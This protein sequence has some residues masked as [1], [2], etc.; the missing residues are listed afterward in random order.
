MKTL[1]SRINY[2]KADIEDKTSKIDTLVEKQHDFDVAYAEAE[3]RYENKSCH[4]MNN[5]ERT[6][7][8]FQSWFNIKS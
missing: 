5:N 8:R 4:E 2:A 1:V 6:N 3:A 7:D